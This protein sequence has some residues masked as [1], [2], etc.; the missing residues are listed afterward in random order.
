MLTFF[1]VGC[2][3]RET[4]ANIHADRTSQRTVVFLSR[5]IATLR[6][7][8]SFRDVF[9]QEALP[10]LSYP[11]VSQTPQQDLCGAK[12]ADSVAGS[13][14]VWIDA[15]C[16]SMHIHEK[17]ELNQ[18]RKLPWLALDVRHDLYESPVV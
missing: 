11:P 14:R 3:R 15:T 13:T 18:W 12:P 4:L 17:L 5:T 8:G 6:T 16:D 1:G 2:E 7:V 10:P 9:F